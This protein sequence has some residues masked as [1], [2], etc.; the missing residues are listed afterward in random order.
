MFKWLKKRLI[1]KTAQEEP[2]DW[3]VMLRGLGKVWWASEYGCEKG[4]ENAT[5][6]TLKEAQE[7]A[8]SYSDPRNEFW[9]E[10]RKV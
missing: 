8:K 5:R 1:K 2:K 10:I 4:K 9:A 7:Y 6:M 3:C